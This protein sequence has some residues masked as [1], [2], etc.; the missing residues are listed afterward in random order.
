MGL[1][2]EFRTGALA[3]SIERLRTDD[4]FRSLHRIIGRTAGLLEATGVVELIRGLPPT[5]DADGIRVGTRRRRPPSRSVDPA[6]PLM[7]PFE[8]TQTSSELGCT[9][10]DRIRSSQPSSTATARGS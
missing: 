7:R 5:V 8:L 6:T 9:C 2:S 10:T 3:A 1:T 4:E